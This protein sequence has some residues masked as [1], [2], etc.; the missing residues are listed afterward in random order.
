M[1]IIE[2][3]CLLNCVYH[4]D[5]VSLPVA[6]ETIRKPIV[7]TDKDSGRQKRRSEV[8]KNEL[9]RRMLRVCENNG[10][11]YRYVLADSWFSY[12]ASLCPLRAVQR[13]LTISPCGAV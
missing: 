12:K 5:G 8:S 9:M 2:R 10:L 3:P 13:R 1:T 6:Y 7:F 11:R 4:S